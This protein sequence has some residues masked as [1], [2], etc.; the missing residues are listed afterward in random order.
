[1]LKIVDGKTE[2]GDLIHGLDPS[3]VA[4]DGLSPTVSF[5]IIEPRDQ[6]IGEFYVV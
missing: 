5:T 1:M 3:F 4:L 6:G 2:K